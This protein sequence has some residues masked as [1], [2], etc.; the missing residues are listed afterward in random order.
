MFIRESIPPTPV[1]H[2]CDICVIGGSCTGVFAAVAAARMGMKVAVVEGNNCFGGVAT[3][4]L[5]SIWHKLYDMT[6]QQRIIAGLTLEMIDRLRARGDLYIGGKD[7]PTGHY[8]VNTEELKIELDRLVLESGIRPFLHTRF[9]APYM[10]DDRIVAAVIEDKT[11]RRAIRAACFI[12]ASGDGDL[13][14]RAGFPTYKRPRMQPPTTC[15][16]IQGLEELARRDPA[17]ALN[18]VLFNPNCPD[19]LK[20]GFLWKRKLPRATDLTMISGTRVFGADCSDAEQLTQAEIEGR[21][22]VRRMVDLLRAD[23]A[24]SEVVSLTGMASYIGIRETR[25]AHCLHTLTQDEL[26]GGVRFPDAIANGTYPVD[27]HQADSP[28]IIFRHL[29]GT[30]VFARPDARNEVRRWRA[31]LP[32]EPAFYQIPYRCL[33]PQ[34]AVNLL[35]AGR[36]IDADEGAFGAIRVMVNCNQTGQAAG[37]AAALAVK[38]GQPVAE[39]P[40]ADLL[41][42]LRDQGAAVVGPEQ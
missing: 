26:L 39:V 32:V 29:D 22:Q 4:G 20:P 11:G 28:G 14:A 6:G 1:I 17:F 38:A 23:C 33:V 37:V 31:P 27:I 8:V 35:A 12:D 18:K 34:G 30:E 36:V 13:I 7:E 41:A 2:D 15:A 25:H 40:P 16:V 5:V 9:V 3:A 21:R 10:E 42:R 19:P 24:G